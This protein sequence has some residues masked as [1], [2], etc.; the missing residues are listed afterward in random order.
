M[1]K[2]ILAFLIIAPLLMVALYAADRQAAT[3]QA[4]A[5]KPAVAAPAAGSGPAARTV[6]REVPPARLQAAEVG[7]LPHDAVERPRGLHCRGSRDPLVR[8]DAADAGRR[9]RWRRRQGARYGP[10]GGVLPAARRR[11][12]RRR[13]L[14]PRTEGQARPPGHL[15]F[16]HAVGRDDVDDGRPDQRADG[17]P[18]RQ[19]VPDVGVDP[20]ALRGRG[21]QDLARHPPEPGVPRGP[22]QAREGLDGS[23]A[24]QPKPEP[25]GR[26]QHHVGKA[27]VRR[28]LAHYSRGH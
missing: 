7:G 6:P 18:G 13:A 26:R 3:P 15:R 27:D 22:D 9:W 23:A 28:G 20:H 25:D 1:R 5:V 17:V 11:R 16:R 24:P 10:R 14:V 4:P 8:G 12:R 2:R 21:P 19:R